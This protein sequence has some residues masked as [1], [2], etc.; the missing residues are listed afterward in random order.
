MTAIWMGLT[1]IKKETDSG[2]LEIEGDPV[3]ARSI[4]QWLG[5]SAFADEPRRV[6]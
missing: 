5:F 2:Q 1:T 3:L 6:Q 4:R